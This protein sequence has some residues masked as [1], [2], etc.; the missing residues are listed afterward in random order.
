MSHDHRERPKPGDP[1]YKPLRQQ[2]REKSL[3]RHERGNWSLADLARLSPLGLALFANK[4]MWET[5]AHMRLLNRKLVDVAAGRTKRLLVELHPRAGKSELISHYFPAWYLGTT[6]ERRVLLASYDQPFAT[7]WSR[8]ARQ[9]LI[10]HGQQV[11]GLRVSER[12][13]TA[14]WWDLPGHRGYMFASGVGGGMTGK[15]GALLI[16]DDPVKSAEQVRSAL[17]RDRT[18]EWYRSHAYPRLEE[19]GGAVVLVMSRW[20]EDD[21]AGRLLEDSRRGG[22]QWEE[23][24]IPALADGPDD[25]LGRAEGEAMWPSHFDRDQL[26][27]IKRTLGEYWF[28]ALYQ[29]RPRGEEGAQFMREQ[30][31]WFMSDGDDFVLDLA[32]GQKQR[33]AEAACGRF[34]TVDLA[35][36]EKE[37]AD[38]T[39][40][41]ACAIA[42][43]LGL[44][45]LDVMRDRVTPG[46]HVERI[47]QHM[48]EWDCPYAL[49]E[50]VQFQADVVA[51]A[52]RRGLVAERLSA[53]GD[54]LTRAQT[55]VKMWNSGQVW[56]PANAS[57][58][59][60]FLDEVCG[61][62][63]AA[64]DDQVDALAYACIA[65]AKHL[66]QAV[67]VEPV[68]IVRRSPWDLSAQR[69]AAV[70][71]RMVG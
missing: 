59:S 22:E 65:A 66:Q 54:K 5:P 24:R 25:P 11:F 51:R 58:A 45:V 37:T 33:I 41:L 1:D 29:G 57:W 46:T 10:E 13:G 35:I 68:S 19:Q 48:R 53:K 61:F 14:E 55:A 43:N 20:H 30:V 7:S 6:P 56:L 32:N 71:P 60:V 31:R 2:I 49:I 44:I 17:M 16:I 8:Q 27:R 4:G 52:R 26:E 42:P 12:N 64:H 40:S 50:A 15:G 38:Y 62:P 70:L 47:A 3:R 23:L 67:A 34:V 36:S 28:S 21:L 69:D 9:V 63:L 39:V 18:W